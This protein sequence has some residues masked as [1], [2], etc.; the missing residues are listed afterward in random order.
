MWAPQYQTLTQA[1]LSDAHGLGLVV[2]PWTVNQP[3][4]IRRLIQWGVDGLITD[5]PDLALRILAQAATERGS[6]RSDGWNQ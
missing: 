2:L 4:D 3:P 1:R 6:V 5:R